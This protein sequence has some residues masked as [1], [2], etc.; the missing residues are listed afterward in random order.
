MLNIIRKVLPCE[1]CSSQLQFLSAGFPVSA[2]LF[3]RRYD[4]FFRLNQR[5]SLAFVW[6]YLHADP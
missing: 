1:A 5:S 3:I 2:G 4:A 6:H